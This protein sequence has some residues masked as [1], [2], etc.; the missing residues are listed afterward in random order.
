MFLPLPSPLLKGEGTSRIKLI[1]WQSLPF[2]K[3]R[4]RGI[5][6]SRIK[7]DFESCVHPKSLSLVIEITYFDGH[8]FDVKCLDWLYVW[9]SE[10][11]NILAQLSPLIRDLGRKCID[12]LHMSQP[13]LDEWSQ[14][15]H[16]K[17]TVR[18]Y[19]NFVSIK[20]LDLLVNCCL[21]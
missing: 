6:K 1:T 10:K 4:F 12:Q 18:I 16:G 19:L 20:V 9:H 7:K 11:L 3:G 21:Y 2:L 17:S 14:K 5:Q 15:L 13:F 8:I